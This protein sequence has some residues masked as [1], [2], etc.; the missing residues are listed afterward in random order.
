MTTA[1]IDIAAFLD[2]AFALFQA[3]DY[4]A[5]V[6]L[7]DEAVKDGSAPAEGLLVRSVAAYLLG[8]LAEASRMAARAQQEAPAERTPSDIQAVLLSLAGD[9]VGATFERKIAATKSQNPDLLRFIDLLPD[10]TTVYLGIAERPLMARGRSAFFDGDL[11]LAEDCFSQQL[12]FEPTNR[13]AH[14]ALAQ[15]RSMREDPWSAIDYLRVAAHQLPGDAR[16]LGA[17]GLALGEIGQ[18]SEALACHRSAE[19]AAPDDAH[20]AGMHLLDRLRDPAQAPSSLASGFAQWGARFAWKTADAL[21]AAPRKTRRTIVYV[22]GSR[23]LSSWGQALAEVI[24]NH[25]PRAFRVIGFGLGSLSQPYNMSYQKCFDRWQDTA[26]LEP[27]TVRAMLKAEGVDILVY[28]DGL[29]DPEMLRLMGTRIAPVQLLWGDLP[30]GSGLPAIDG[31]VTDAFVDAGEGKPL[32]PAACLDLPAGLARLPD[33]S[34]PRA[35]GES[36]DAVLFAADA[37]MREINPVTV[38]WW[39]AALAAV[40]NATLLLKD[41]ALSSPRA[42]D[43]L[44]G[45]FGNFGLT[46]RIDV[47]SGQSRADLFADVDLVLGALPLSGAQVAADA[48]WAGVPFLCPVPAGRHGR[49]GGA[50]L[51]ALGYG[52]LM[53]AD[54]PAAFGRLAAHWIADQPGRRALAAEARDRLTSAPALDPRSI[55]AAFEKAVDGLWNAAAAKV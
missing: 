26:G 16:V 3:K 25:D 33:S 32:E 5:A 37:T 18:S 31:L 2:E 28:C 14:L 54:R 30:Y 19:S 21:A 36:A 12:H 11:D 43:R 9:L 52:D 55:C 29:H 48:L 20:L 46:H 15:C 53:L 40:P 23:G 24:V 8:D 49:E 41:N 10:F 1:S 34:A 39:A 44:L 51:Q 17:L 45:L 4:A 47:I 13:E 35:T 42:V 27:H 50:L 22:V 38:E 7:A 6:K